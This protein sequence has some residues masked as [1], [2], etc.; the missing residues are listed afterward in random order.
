MQAW[1][2]RASDL[3]DAMSKHRVTL[4]AHHASRSG[5]EA[6]NLQSLMR[7]A[8][9]YRRSGDLAASVATWQ[10][11]F[12]APRFGRP[13]YDLV[14]LALLVQGEALLVLSEVGLRRE[15]YAP[16]LALDDPRLAVLEDAH[17][18]TTK[19]A[20]MGGLV[21]IQSCQG[22][23][24]GH[25]AP[26][27]AAGREALDRSAKLIEQVLPHFKLEEDLNRILQSAG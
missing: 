10:Q 18:L 15:V 8:D 1:L 21:V 17:A 22:A 5:Q 9:L 24:L 12:P 13:K 26:T 20:F 6:V 19:Q 23:D 4:E 25:Q 14:K 3:A 16:E 11:G 2:E 27:L 7:E